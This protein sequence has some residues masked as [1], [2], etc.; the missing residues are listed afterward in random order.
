[1]RV[2]IVTGENTIRLHQFINAELAR[3]LPKAERVTIPHAG[4]GS[5]RENSQA[6]NDAVTRFLTG[7]SR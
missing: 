6:F 3:L 7:R 4:H 1:M 5:A 2:L